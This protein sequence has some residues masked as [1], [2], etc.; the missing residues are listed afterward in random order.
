[1]SSEEQSDAEFRSAFEE[2]ARALGGLPSN[3]EAGSDGSEPQEAEVSAEERAPEAEQPG[4]PES[5]SPAP[6]E[7]APVK[8][9]PED[10]PWASAPDHL[11]QLHEA[12]VQ[13]L[14]FRARSAAGRASHLQ[15]RLNELTE[16]LEALEKAAKPQTDDDLERVRSEYPDVVNPLLTRLERQEQLLKSLEERLSAV[17]SETAE[18][19]LSRLHPDW[20]EV[21]PGSSMHEDFVKWVARQGEEIVEVVQ[22]NGQRIVDPEAVAEVLTMFKRDTGR[23]SRTDG[24][25]QG[26]GSDVR[27]RLQIVG[28]MGGRPPAQSTVPN[29]DVAV[30]E[31]EAAFLER[32][33]QLGSL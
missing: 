32:A 12:E 23:L 1:M 11:R 17:H 33:R 10:D 9:T 5:P 15:R 16:R 8:A 19:K 22:A 31:F 21:R 30:S 24:A 29:T 6:Q 2:R 7:G 4:L 28:A 26:N 3:R 27:R 13:K 25:R 18:D 20:T 14:S